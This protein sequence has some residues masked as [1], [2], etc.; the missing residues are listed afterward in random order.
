MYKR[1]NKNNRGNGEILMKKGVK[2]IIIIAVLFTI[3]GGAILYF[4]G[5]LHQHDIVIDEAVAATCSA[6]GRTEGSHCETCGKVIKKQQKLDKL[7]HTF[8]DD[9]QCTVCGYRRAYTEVEDD[10]MLFGVYPQSDVTATM[11]EALN[12]YAG[13]LPTAEA[14]GDWTSFGY[15]LMG[16]EANF[17]WYKD[18]S[19]GI[20]KY[21]AVYFVKY[22]P[23]LT[24]RID[25][26]EDSKQFA[27]GYLTEQIYWF[28]FEPIKWRIIE[29]A[30]GEALMIADMI[31]NAHEFNTTTSGAKSSSANSWELSTVRKWLN[32]NFYEEAF[33]AEERKLI[34]K[35]TV[36]NGE[37]VAQTEDYIYLASREE[38]ENP[39]YGFA[40]KSDRIFKATDYARANGATVAMASSIKGNGYF[41]L[42]T[43]SANA[44]N[45]ALYVKND[46][47][48]ASG[49]FVNSTTY[50]IL[51]MLKIELG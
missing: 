33:T 14:S 30:D 49:D 29:R 6:E 26:Q 18:V 43:P 28:K 24:S 46:G 39:A 4:G 42:R 13:I 44:V 11:G 50:G 17:M 23:I 7:P 35:S 21:R 22:R 38:I 15:M 1:I 51:P 20:E 3:V 36:S 45:N 25:S 10:Y 8:N 32:E 5:F 12:E 47:S 9:G 31:I 2:A 27:N 16:E 37:D 48:V 19:I 40:E 41:W 34:L